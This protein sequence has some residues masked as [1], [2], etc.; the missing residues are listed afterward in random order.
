MR[1]A[2]SLVLLVWVGCASSQSDLIDVEQN[3][4]GVTHVEIAR[5]TAG[6]ERMLEIRGL[7]AGGFELAVLRLRTG[8]VYYGE[9]NAQT[10]ESGATGT[11]L[12]I[13]VADLT[14]TAVTPDLYPH[15]LNPMFDGADQFVRLAAVS[16][17][18]ERE[19]GISVVVPVANDDETAYGT[20][21]GTCPASYMRTT[22]LAKSC[23]F[24]PS[25]SVGGNTFHI[26][27]AT[28]RVVTRAHNPYGTKCKASNGTGTCSGTGCF[29]GPC[30]FANPVFFTGTGTPRVFMEPNPSTGWTGGSN[31]KWGFNTYNPAPIQLVG[32]VTGTCAATTCP[33]GIQAA[34]WSY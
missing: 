3:E 17:E 21:S 26:D 1:I 6:G 18:L 9:E 10:H 19:A 4:L 15:P 27:Q 25:S 28:N 14:A 29:Y 13:T 16:A 2:H 22:P 5:S 30:G 8:T 32:D 12:A 20:S 31:C 11:E 34:A 24:D 33:G 23:C 7:D